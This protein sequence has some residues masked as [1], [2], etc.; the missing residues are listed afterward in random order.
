MGAALVSVAIAAGLA[1]LLESWLRLPNLSMMFLIPVIF[2]AVR[3]GLWTAIAASVLSFFAF[4]FFFVD[5][6]YEFTISQ[7]HEF[8]SLIVFLVVAVITAMLASRAREHSLGMGT[9]VQAA[10]SMFEFSR[11][12]SGAAKLDDVLWAAAV[13]AQKALDARCIVLLRPD[14]G[15]LNICAAWP[16]MDQLDAGEAS[17]ARWTLKKSEPAG[18]RTGTL[19]NVRFQFR[20]LATSRGVVGVCGVEPKIAEEPLS[21]QDESM[22]TSILEQTAIA[23]DRALLVDESVKAAALEENEKLRTMLLASLSHDLRTPLASITGAVTSLLQ[24]GD[25]MPAPDRRDLL[26]SIEEEAGRLSRF[27]ANLLDMSRIESGALAPRRDL[28]DV[29]DVVRSAVARCRKVFPEQEIALSIA[30]D[31]PLIRAD[32]N[33]LA[34]VLFNLL[35]NAH[36]YGGDSGAIIH[37]RR[38]GEDVVVT[39]TDEGPGVKPAD[40]ERIFEKFYRGGRPDGRKAGTGLGL[41]I[42]RGLV[43]AMGGTIIAQSPAIRQARHAHRPAFSRFRAAARGHGGMSAIRVL[44]V[45][46]EPQIHRFLRPALTACG[47]E[48]LDGGDR[49]RRLAAHR[50]RRSRRGRSRP[51]PSRHG[52]QGRSCGRPA[53]SRRFRSSFYRRETKRPRKSWRSTLAPTIMSKSH[54]RS[55]NSWLGC[56]PPC[57]TQR[58]ENASRRGSRAGGLCIDFVKRLV[59]KN[60]V[61]VKLTPKEYDVLA[62]LASHA[63]R[64]LT[65]RQLL[66][67]VWGPAHQEDTQYLRVFIGQLR[68]KIE[69]DSSEPRLVLTEP[70]MGYRFTDVDQ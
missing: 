10:Q 48:V 31:L 27:V 57:A 24:L 32:A 12:L 30:R 45:D 56:A 65:H 58:M 49:P 68:A 43:E 34:Q 63:G 70:G 40:L 18:W 16:P 29:A 47:Y 21:A 46:D 5:P 61:A 42:C 28:V 22:L 67:A 1:H 52:R 50:H 44:V 7:P 36:K 64:L 17:A 11:K 41:S 15:E 33:L 25:K 69:E 59:T 53:A 9:R 6:R 4:D 14:D 54:S 62:M 20:P 3:F 8:F 39:V 66:T 60:G 13:H 35:D 2:C 51:R 23:I 37:A 26:I 38:E 19:P 55:A